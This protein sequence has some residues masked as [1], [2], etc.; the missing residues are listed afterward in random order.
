[1][2]KISIF[3]EGAGE[4]IFLWELAKHVLAE[5]NAKIVTWFENGG[6]RFQRVPMDE[7]ELVLGTGRDLYLQIV[8]SANEDLVVEDAIK[9]SPGLA[10][11]NFSQIVVVR[12]VAPNI[13]RAD[14][15]KLREGISNS[16]R[17]SP[18]PTLVVLEIMEFEAWLLSMADYYHRIDQ[19]L[20][21][22][23][24]T[25]SIGVFPS[26]ANCHE[27]DR[28][29]DILE[30]I[31]AIADINAIKSRSVVTEIIRAFDFD[32]LVNERAPQIDDLNNLIASVGV[33]PQ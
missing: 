7:K 30:E 18:V 14:I 9:N 31:M 2:I 24:I 19:R 25:E 5:K 17:G 23:A 10:A 8:N 26:S 20:T 11:A 12:D 29:S 15:P 27:F 32:V 22:E 4:A 3:V 33:P 21:R 13:S 16:L 1:M 6:R 28:P